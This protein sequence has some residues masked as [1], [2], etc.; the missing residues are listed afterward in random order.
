MLMGKC[1]YPSSQ[2]VLFGVADA[3][4]PV[5]CI[6]LDITYQGGLIPSSTTGHEF[7]PGAT[8]TFN[9]SGPAGHYMITE[10]VSNATDLH[11]IGPQC[12]T[13]WGFMLR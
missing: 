6:V 2:S 11:R 7:V 8:R 4:S 1:E 13:C 10:E 3:D 12:H 9:L 5:P